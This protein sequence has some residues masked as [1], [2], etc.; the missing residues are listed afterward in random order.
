MPDAPAKL[1][2]T[3]LSTSESKECQFNPKEFSISKSVAWATDGASKKDVPHW[4]FGGGNPATLN[5]P[6]LFFD[7]TSTGDDVRTKYTNFLLDLLKIDKNKT[8][9]NGN[10]LGEPPDCRFA[11]GT[12]LAFVAVVERVDLTYTFFLSDGTPVRAKAKLSLK[13]KKDEQE[14]SGQNP[15][16]RSRARKTWVVR[17]G[18]TLDWIAYKEYGNPA[19]WRHIAESNDLD[20]PRQLRA[21]Q[22]LRLLPLD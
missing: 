4:S 10:L 20:N 2:I 7:T 13:Q 18:E 6:E 14:Q 17:E 3:N 11:W 8:D 19:C 9:D 22:I 5:V 15:T 21:G 12:F 16:T 1:T